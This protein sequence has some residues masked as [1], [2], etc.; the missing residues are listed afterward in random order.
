MSN[1]QRAAAPVSDPAPSAVADHARAPARRVATALAVWGGAYALYRGYYAVGG[2][3]G[4]IG[5]P[6]SQAQFRAVNGVGAAVIA[7][8]AAAPPV[9]VRARPLRRLLPALGWLGAVGCCMHALVDIVLRLLSVTGVH[10]TR[11]PA[12]FWQSFDRRAA[13]LQDLLL[14]EP[15]FFV[16][17]VLSAALGVA[18]VHPSRRRVWLVSAAL[19]CTAATVVGVLSGL[20]VIG[21]IHLG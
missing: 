5:E 19:A 11:L 6:L 9:C 21:Q 15:W 4:M 13:D 10:P 8:A 17:G 12:S 20:G 16:E 1:R 14:N 18:L 3:V 2:Q 7:L